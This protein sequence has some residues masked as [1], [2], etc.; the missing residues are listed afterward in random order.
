MESLQ[1]EIER[2]NE[3]EQRQTNALN[4]NSRILIETSNDI[5]DVF[6]NLI[7]AIFLGGILSALLQ[8]AKEINMKTELIKSILKMQ[9]KHENLRYEYILERSYAE[10]ANKEDRQNIINGLI[11]DGILTESQ[12]EG[13]T[14]LKIHND[15]PELLSYW[16]W[17]DSFRI[18]AQKTLNKNK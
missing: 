13:D 15:N 3:S 17:L 18:D 5:K 10:N 4:E 11:Y 14:I 1:Y 8:K 7:G 16:Q 12:I 6:T 2:L 9:E